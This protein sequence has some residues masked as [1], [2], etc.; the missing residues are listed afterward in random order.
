MKSLVAY[1]AYQG[2]DELGSV[3]KELGLIPNCASGCCCTTQHQGR[4]RSV[5]TYCKFRMIIF[6]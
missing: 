1:G 2:L 3:G 5:H 4:Q 6:A